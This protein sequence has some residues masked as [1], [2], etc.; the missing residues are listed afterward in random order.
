[1]TGAIPP[2]RRSH[3]DRQARL[4][5]FEALEREA[6]QFRS[7]EGIWPFRVPHDPISLDEIVDQALGDE[8][9]PLDALKS[10]TV[11]RMIF[12]ADDRHGVDHAWEA[13]AIA[14]P[15][16]IMLYCDDDGDERRILASVK[17]GAPVEADGF[18]LE[19]LAETRGHAFGIE[20][21]ATVPS[22]IQTSIP[23]R[24]L[25]VEV[26][27]ELFEGTPA[28]PVMEAIG[29]RGSRVDAGADRDFRSDVEQWLDRVLPPGA[30]GSTRRLP[31]RRDEAP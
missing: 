2:H 12:D 29:P 8:R 27:L 20:M 4:R 10:R 23:D 6:K 16:G 21:A 19:L 26:F 25:L 15:S 18:F 24:E 13:W 11:L 30:S 9:L 5:A 22:R 31:R 7:F 1:M 28:Q 17:R 14:L 3:S